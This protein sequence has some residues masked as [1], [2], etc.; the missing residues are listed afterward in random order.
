MADAAR[1]AAGCIIYAGYKKRDGTYS[2]DLLT[3]KSRLV[4]NTIP[5]NELEG[6]RLMA[7]MM[8]DRKKGRQDGRAECRTDGRKECR[9][10]AGMQECRRQE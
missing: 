2:C 8:E 6:V 10:N 5:R 3:A 9:Q 7:G 1:E 4:S